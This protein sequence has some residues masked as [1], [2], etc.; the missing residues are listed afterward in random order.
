MQHI[1][2]RFQYKI[3]EANIISRPRRIFY[4]DANVYL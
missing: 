2:K 3:I 4:M 1:V